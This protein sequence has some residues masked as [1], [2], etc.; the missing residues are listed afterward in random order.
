MRLG[1]GASVASRSP[2]RARRSGRREGAELLEQ[3]RI[4]SALVRRL[5]AAQ[6]PEW[7]VLPVEPVVPGGW[8]NRTFRLGRDLSVRLPSGA[9]YVAQVAKE[10]AWLPKLAQRLPLPVPAPV[11][12]GAP[13]EG[14]PWPWSVYRWIDGDR[15]T[16]E[17]AL[18]R[19]ALAV[20]LA[21]FLSALQ[22]I[23]TAGGPPP[24]RHNFFRGGPLSVY[25]AETR[26]AI[27]VLGARVDGAAAAAIWREAMLAPR[28]G[29]PVW[30]H[31]DVA[32]SNLLVRQGRLC[33]VIDFGC[34]GIGD[35]SC[36]LAIAWTL[37][38]G[39]SRTAFRDAL[40]LDAAAWARG[41]GWALWKA[42]IT[43]AETD[44]AAAKVAE[45]RRVLDELLAERQG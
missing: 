37:F 25:D 41:R 17:S 19:R 14:Y 8:D 3:V 21:D 27:D 29:P 7:A 9:A 5:V 30:L 33:A 36:D 45:A 42:L 43:L 34:C 40:P 1:V 13:G 6:L 26:H 11:A 22:R 18:D 10:H 20:A 16:P 39:D 31:G 12:L 15:V 23:D 32:A 4:D 44:V 28:S 24:G 38:S 35:P 2:A